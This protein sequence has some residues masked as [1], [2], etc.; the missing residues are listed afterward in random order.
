MALSTPTTISVST[1]YGVSTFDTHLEWA[2]AV[3][4][5]RRIVALDPGNEFAQSLLE[6]EDNDRYMSEKQ[7]NWVY[8]LAQD[9]I[10]DREFSSRV[11]GRAVDLTTDASNILGALVEANTK[12]IKQPILRLMM[13]NGAQ[14]RVKYMTRGG[15][16]GGAWVT[17]GDE[18]RGKITDQ[19]EFT[20]YNC[21]YQRADWIADLVEYINQVN[22]DVDKALTTYGKLT[23]KCGCCG[24]PLTNKESIERGIG[25]ICLDKYGFLA[26]A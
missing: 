15:N 4:E 24:L 16:I 9:A 2:E 13:H 5:L 17:V 7:V 8:K 6:R 12:G 3:A 26:L 1:R 14:V 20:P 22:S 21:K 10:N 25:P 11:V 23:S 18:L 19:G